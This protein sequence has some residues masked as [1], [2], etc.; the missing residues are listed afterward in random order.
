M[1]QR[2]IVSHLVD[3]QCLAV[4]AKVFYGFAPFH[5]RLLC[6]AMFFNPTIVRIQSCFATPRPFRVRFLCFAIFFDPPKV[7]R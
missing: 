6:F 4:K 3:C 2:R 1:D 7:R 5:V